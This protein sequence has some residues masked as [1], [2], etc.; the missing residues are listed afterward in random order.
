MTQQKIH[1]RF[2]AH[3]DLEKAIVTVLTI[4][5]EPIPRSHIRTIL[6]GAGIRENSRRQ[7][8]GKAVGEAIKKLIESGLAHSSQYGIKIAGL[9]N[10][11]LLVEAHQADLLAPISHSIELSTR[12]D[13]NTRR[14]YSENPRLD[15]N[16]MR[17]LAVMGNS[18]AI[19]KHIERFVDPPTNECFQPGDHRYSFLTIPGDDLIFPHVPEEIRSQVLSA[20][21]PCL[22]SSLTPVEGFIWPV[23]E[24]PEA[25]SVSAISAVTEA[26]IFKG[27]FLKAADLIRHLLSREEPEAIPS[28]AVHHSWLATATGS[29]TSAR[30]SFE[31]SVERLLQ[32]TR[33]RKAYPGGFSSAFALLSFVEEG[34]RES[35]STA[36]ETSKFGKRNAPAFYQHS[37]G[38]TIDACEGLAGSESPY[39]DSI[40]YP[41]QSPL[42]DWLRSYRRVWFGD[43]YTPSADES[44]LLNASEWAIESGFLWIA[45]EIETLRARICTSDTQRKKSAKLA[46]KL[47]AE[48]GTS[49]SILNCLPFVEPWE[50][51]LNALE[52]LAESNSPTPT[53][54]NDT[55]TGPRLAW[56]IEFHDAPHESP[57]QHLRNLLASHGLD[58]EMSGL[59]EESIEEEKNYGDHSL[60]IYAV[61]QTP[62]RK[63]WTKGK[64]ISAR[65]L[66]KSPETFPFLTP[67]DLRAIAKIEVSS[68]GWYSSSNTY[69]FLVPA[70]LHTLIGHPAIFERNTLENDIYPAEIIEASPEIH[71]TPD[72]D[73][74]VIATLKPA[75]PSNE[76]H[77]VER[78]GTARYSATQFSQ[79]HIKIAESLTP[80]G[81][82]VPVNAAPRLS[83]A[84]AGLATTIQVRSE[85]GA[86]QAADTTAAEIV[87]SDPKP[88][89]RL[90]PT[91]S[92]LEAELC[93][94]PI[95]AVENFLAPGTGSTTLM[96]NADGRAVQTT[97]D[98]AA[99]SSA[100]NAL[101]TACPIFASHLRDTT[102]LPT[103]EFAETA[104]ALEAL[105]QL[106]AANAHLVW[107]KG[108]PYKVTGEA[109]TSALHVTVKKADDWFAASAELVLDAD[110]VFNTKQLLALLDEPSTGR[111]VEVSKGKFLAL[112]AGLRRQ[113]DELKTLGTPSRDKGSVQLHPLA[114]GIF[115]DTF[116][117]AGK[118][119][120]D[121]AWKKQVKRFESA[122]AVSPKLPKTLQAEL[123]PYQ[124]EGFRWLSQLAA[125][126]AGACLADDM[127]LGKTIQT[128]ALLL[129]RA[130]EGPALVVAPTSVVPNWAAETRK[131]APTLNIINYS[132]TRTERTSLLKQL[133]PNT[134]VIVSYALLQIDSEKFS[135]TQWH[136]T[137]LDEAQAIKNASTKRAK[138]ALSLRSDFRI[139]TTGTPVENRLDELFSLFAFLNPGLLGSRE[140]F[141]KT[142]ATPIE[143]DS[144]TSARSRLKTL[145]SPFVLR[146]LKSAVL[147][148]L[149]AR[150]ET[151]LHIE[152]A[153]EEAAFYEGLRQR[154]VESLEKNTS[155][156][157]ANKN[158]LQILAEIMKLRRACCSPVLAVKGKAKVAAPEGSKLAA[159]GN[160]VE[161]LLAGGHRALVFSQFVDHLKLLESHLKRE[162]ISY[163]Y[164]DG[165]T[166]AKQREKK[167]ANFQAGE[168]DIFLISLKAGGTGLNLTGADYVIHM[169][170]WW[171]PAVE[172]QASDRAHRIGQTRPVTVYRM[173]MKG[174][175]E[176][177]IVELHH[178][179]RD[180]ADSLLEGTD[181]AARL[182]P[183]DMLKLIQ[184]A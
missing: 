91:A 34:S 76:I 71:V 19:I 59:F 130:K 24:S 32:G 38:L 65:R 145:I 63:G 3:T 61:K 20:S 175:I 107:P 27:D 127:G 52:T 55:P 165:S 177:Q 93:V 5:G 174:T 94:Q 116:S 167:V 156:D 74:H 96:G 129:A 73:H 181:T 41:A 46:A 58:E 114:T 88:I 135:K 180:L 26:C 95:S 12:N 84:L 75:P 118:L 98:L 139:A 179:K 80:S 90:I 29:F 89:F 51:H 160:L 21:L 85:S 106:K 87:D 64:E 31:K 168:G 109:D 143:R 72:G 18:A 43:E 39:K 11:G 170:P 77:L 131:F 140:R 81:L 2:T 6:P 176:E 113:L 92:G 178:K 115:D 142:F 69:K 151:T 141:A 86:L 183:K 13:Y 152:M 123:R 78:T 33:K 110:L 137:V 44:A 40:N 119:S 15:K 28:A 161:E 157:D 48:I 54:A 36:K 68:G 53:K 159:F 153:P 122:S 30:W 60:E 126:G 82:R 163:Q 155:E 49:S 10:G 144:S 35:L 164:L 173:V 47:S 169:D 117:T 83:N 102:P 67:Q 14:Y 154:A 146:R 120:T 171:N 56:I 66:C 17:R 162:G 172:D 138:A 104:N 132:G 124:E 103:Y 9:L 101:L 100:A 22:V 133:K 1:E 97:R 23:L 105:F 4:F 42:F 45:Y 121:T 147:D 50:R 111:F 57:H 70:T 16:R 184:Q 150:T 62:T 99:E 149:P 134:L 37:A 182:T 158:S 25:F 148:D 136:T 166:P 125:L 8:T 108:E 128:L 7:Y 79:E 112:T